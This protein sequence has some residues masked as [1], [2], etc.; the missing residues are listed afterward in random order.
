M[1]N[2]L[3]LHPNYIYRINRIKSRFSIIVFCRLLSYQTAGDFARNLLS[4]KNSGLSID[5]SVRLFS[6]NY[7]A[8]EALAQYIARCPISRENASTWARLITKVYGVLP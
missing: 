7:K 3:F 4:W 6:S 2:I 5:N 1:N 8:K